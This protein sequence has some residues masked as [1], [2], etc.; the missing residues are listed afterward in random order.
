[1]HANHAYKAAVFSG[2][3]FL[4][5]TA[6]PVNTNEMIESSWD[7]Y[8]TRGFIDGFN[9]SSV[10]FLH[11]LS[12][13]LGNRTSYIKEMT[14]DVFCDLQSEVHAV[15]SMNEGSF[16]DYRSRK[17][18]SIKLKNLIYVNPTYTLR[19][20]KLGLNAV[21]SRIKLS[22]IYKIPQLTAPLFCAIQGAGMVTSLLNNGFRAITESG[23]EILW[24]RNEQLNFEVGYIDYIFEMHKNLGNTST[25][26]PTKRA[27]SYRLV[28]ANG[29]I[30]YNE[31]E[32]IP[33]SVYLEGAKYISGFFAVSAL[34]FILEGVA[35]K[36]ISLQQIKC[37][38]WIIKIY[39]RQYHSV[40][41]I[42]VK[43]LQE[44]WFRR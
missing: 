22:Q 17:N 14:K 23:I 44:K 32:P 8:S 43:Q 20:I 40:I 6:Y 12:K 31:Y 39:G 26:R 36:Q 2:S 7:K 15:Y 4:E 9:W 5:N 34:T 21:N 11:L 42:K 27:G 29:L 19:Q 16:S 1:M 41:M 18:N 3:H 37:L 24:E 30:S 35:S 10:C 25:A 33:K 13:D 28:L 38:Y